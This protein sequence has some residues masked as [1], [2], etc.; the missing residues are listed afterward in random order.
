MILM[1][2]ILLW[3]MVFGNVV[4]ELVF[5]EGFI[6]L[7]NMVKEDSVVVLFVFLDYFLFSSIISVIVLVMVIIFFVMF[8]D[9]GVMVVD[10]LCFY[11]CNDMLL[12]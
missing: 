9:L 10:M 7:V 4:I 11:G 8:C 12:W 6:E 3:M 1:V 5:I 2:F